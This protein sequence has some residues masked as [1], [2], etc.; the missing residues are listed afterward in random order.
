VNLLRP[1]LTLAADGTL[2]DLAIEQEAPD[3]AEGAVGH[4]VLRPHRIAAGLYSL[5]EGTLVRTT[6]IEADVDGELTPVPLPGGL[7][8][9]VLLLNDDDLTFVKIRLDPG[10]LA[11]VREHIGDFADPLPRALCWG[12]LWDM[13]RDAE[14][15]ARDYTAV[16]LGHVHRETDIGVVLSLQRQVKLAL[17][18]Y[19][20]PQWR[21]AGLAGYADRAFELLAAAPPGSDHQLAWAVAYADVARTGEQLAVLSELLAGD[22]RIAGLVLDPELRWRFLQRL[23]AV[24]MAGEQAIAAESSRDNTALGQRHRA[25]CLAARPV[26]AAKEAAWASLIAPGEL[27]NTMQEAVIAGFI[28][29]DQHELLTPFTARYFAVIKDVFEQ[30]SAQ[31]SQQIIGK[32]YPSWQVSRATLDA[33]DAWLAAVS[34][35]PALRRMVVEGR[36]E[37]A[38]ALRAQEADR[39]AGGR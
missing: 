35:E 38:R 19:A 21:P 32:L 31:I 27:S 11:A 25:T 5:R 36:G 34:P 39:A 28:Q 33:T 13:T 15:A 10:S 37:L 14:L 23:A 22:R 4:P 1:R 20:D 26:A 7:A 6:R 3:L 16:V 12:C 24:G 18:S 2:A 17:D 29:P 8:P 9:T 30:S